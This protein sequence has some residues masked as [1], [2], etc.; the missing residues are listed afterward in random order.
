LR[1]YCFQEFALRY[2]AYAIHVEA[3]TL[4]TNEGFKGNSAFSGLP[5][6]HYHLFAVEVLTEISARKSEEL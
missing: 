2:E 1:I 5:Q 3:L 4:I 6:V